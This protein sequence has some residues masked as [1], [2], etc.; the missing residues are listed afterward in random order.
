M[1]GPEEPLA[2]GLADRLG[3]EGVLA[4][5][6]TAAAARIETSK[7][8]AKDLL[9]EAGVPAAR[10][11]AV[12]DVGSGMAALADFGW[13]LVLKADGL[14]AGKGVVIV[15]DRE[16]VQTVLTAMLEDAVLGAAGQTVLIEEFLEGPEVS[17]LALCDGE[18]VVCLAPARD[19]KRVG[20]GD[21]GPN[22]GGMGAF[23]PVPGLDGAWLAGI[24]RTI[25]APTVA[26]MAARGCPMRGV[27]YAGLILTSQGPVV[28]EYNARF[29]DPE[30]QVVLPLLDGD[31]LD[32]LT[33]VAGGSMAL[34]ISAASGAG[35][36][37][38]VV[39]ASGGYP[40]P[41]QS[42][43]PVTG[44]DRVPDDVLVFHAGTRRDAAGRVVTAGG[45]VLTVVGRGPTLE[46]ARARAYAGADA[47]SFP[48]MRRRSDIGV[49]RS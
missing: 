12:T 31:L 37:V 42:G 30:T 36:A 44:L 34:D 28:L 9:R 18:R 26:T 14:A 22:T 6:P 49:P 19:A 4:F 16:H 11:V 10:S 47:I 21:T 13:P 46:A 35:A 33:G 1:I 23:A 40:G 17:V 41:Y 3:A 8:W 24:E 7:S 29:G 43:L 27:L 15:H 25:L 45:R 32:L 5:G 20:D 48:E 39:L 38:G 2:R